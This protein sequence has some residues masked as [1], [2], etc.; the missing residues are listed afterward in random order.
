MVIRPNLQTKRLA[1]AHA[2][3]LCMVMNGSA[4]FIAL[5]AEHSMGDGKTGDGDCFILPL[6]PIFPSGFKGPVLMK[7]EG[8]TVVSFS[9][10]FVLRLPAAI[11]AWTANPPPAGEICIAVNDTSAYLRFDADRRGPGLLHAYVDFATGLICMVGPRREFAVPAGTLSY[12][13]AW[14]L[15]T[16]EL[17][18]RSILTYPPPQRGQS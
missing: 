10:H 14:E 13:L 6:G 3:E 9:K 2:G 16:D 1:Q 7:E 15:F 11:N 12:A 8:L 4:S 5:V 18:P 17:E